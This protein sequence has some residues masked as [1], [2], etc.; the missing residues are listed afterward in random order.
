MTGLFA[1]CF[2][3]RE[4]G[5]ADVSGAPD[6]DAAMAGRVA[7][8]G[9]SGL[10]ARVAS[11]TSAPNSFTQG[12]GAARAPSI[13]SMRAQLQAAAA[14]A[15]AAVAGVAA[16]A[17]GGGGVGAD[18]DSKPAAAAAPADGDDLGA[19][20]VPAGGQDGVLRMVSLLQELLTLSAPAG[21]RRPHLS[22]AMALLASRLPADCVTLHA[23]APG[24]RCAMLVAGALSPD[25]L[26]ASNSSGYGGSA[27]GASTTGASAGGSVR[28]GGGGGG[29]DGS[30]LELGAAPP[31]LIVPAI[32][33]DGAD[34]DGLVH[35]IFEPSAAAEGA[36]S[37]I[38]AVVSSR[39][40]LSYHLPLSV[41]PPA[42]A[43]DNGEGPVADAA[44]GPSVGACVAS[45]DQLP[46]DW[47][48]LARE[49]GLR[50]FLAIP[51][52][53]SSAA[54]GAAAATAA[55][56]DDD[57]SFIGSGPGFGAA[58]SSGGDGGGAGAHAG[59]AGG[60]GADEVVGVLTFAA[61]SR[62]DWGAAWW[63]P[64]AQLLCGWAAG[65]LPQVRAGART[66]LLEA[67]QRAP[68]LDALAAC[69]VHGLPRV[70]A[71]ARS[72]AVEARVALAGATLERAVIFSAAPALMRTPNTAPPVMLIAGFPA[73]SGGRGGGGGAG[74]GGGSSSSG[75]A[76]PRTASG[77]GSGGR[78][79]LAKVG[80]L[81]RG[82]S[83]ASGGGGGGRD[84]ITSCTS[85][86]DGSAGGT[87]TSRDGD[88]GSGRG[89][90]S[91]ATD[92]AASEE[93]KRA[94]KQAPAPA[95]GAQS[96]GDTLGGDT[97]AA[98]AAAAAA[99]AH[100][101]GPAPAE[102]RVVRTAVRMADTVLLSAL[103][104]GEVMAVKDTMQY[105]GGRGGAYVSRSV[106]GGGAAYPL[107]GARQVAAAGVHHSFAA[108][109]GASS[110]CGGA[111]A[112]PAG[113]ADLFLE[114]RPA[115]RGTLVLLP[116]IYRCRPLGCVY[117][118]ASW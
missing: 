40:S 70:I 48:A 20:L 15:A 25:A 61:A 72:G 50:S 26:R 46:P 33:E 53:S 14:A 73:G 35:G 65:A 42:A 21:L 97:I 32:G 84:G 9:L 74:G 71:D 12:A 113:A 105:F 90:A 1:C 51:V 117:L 92:S 24:A 62:C 6:A 112:P 91:V 116:L 111:G 76:S 60:G 63:L 103:E 11:R 41:P 29:H 52:V 30:F 64:S 10:V 31:F 8:G 44:E 36:A 49:R 86:G 34:N 2:G 39:A 59:A 98:A 104:W 47:A 79:L 81:A 118:L 43:A 17:G 23:V 55:D 18:D 114:G 96:A 108:G 107:H 45:A 80:L 19:S 83:P 88:A 85:N 77:G 22:Q 58:P 37:S 54:R 93:G 13:G 69:L 75:R 38:A 106:G 101:P 27:T 4:A 28:G 7:S 109:Y 87:V 56:A 110:V 66:A 99:H 68:T 102:A 67:V 78:R 115:P 16:P 5:G 57:G 3:G 95:V 94:C 100:R 82:K 89:R